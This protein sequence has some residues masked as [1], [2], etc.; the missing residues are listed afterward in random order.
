[1]TLEEAINRLPQERKKYFADRNVNSIGIGKKMNGEYYL[2]VG[3]K[4]GVAI[5]IEK[6]ADF[7]PIDAQIAR[8]EKTYDS[9]IEVDIEPKKEERTTIKPGKLVYN[10]DTR[11]TYGTISAIVKKRHGLYLTSCEHVL[12]LPYSNSKKVFING[13][14]V[15]DIHHQ[16][17]PE[18]DLALAKI[19]ED[20]EDWVD[21]SILN[22]EAT[23]QFMT[24]PQLD[25]KVIKYG[26]NTG[27]TN[28]RVRLIHV[29]LN[30]EQLKPMFEVGPRII[31]GLSFINK[32][33]S[34][35]L[36]VKEGAKNTAVGVV[37]RQTKYPRID[38]ENGYLKGALV[39][40]IIPLAKHFDFNFY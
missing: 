15:A 24:D 34:G 28:G 38:G 4:P 30:G 16:G 33:D 23:P 31:E 5:A 7:T 37:V 10:K 35:A 21:S 1:M 14:H 18:F 26:S 32:Q 25:M 36:V 9:E 6:I 29:Y 19:H 2:E 8:V 11:K 17:K 13:I 40:P 39:Q 20:K 12:K 3:Y 27:L 22:I